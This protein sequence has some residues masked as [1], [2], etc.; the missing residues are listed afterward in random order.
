MMTR[1]QH[2]RTLVVATL[3]LATVVMVGA[4]AVVQ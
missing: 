1:A 3:A 4:M 2:V